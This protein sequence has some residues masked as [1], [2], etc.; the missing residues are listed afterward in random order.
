MCSILNVQLMDRI[1]VT[2]PTRKTKG[3]GYKYDEVES[4]LEIS[5]VSQS[6][7]GMYRCNVNMIDSDAKSNETS[8][9]IFGLYN[10]LFL[11][12]CVAWIVMFVI[13]IK[14]S[15]PTIRQIWA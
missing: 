3:I 9:D 6:Y 8:I 10:Q 7:E 4:M 2:E 12:T 11:L 13:I 5:N 14:V 1:Q 15:S